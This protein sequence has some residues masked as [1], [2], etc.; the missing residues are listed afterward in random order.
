LQKIS[1]H[2]RMQTLVKSLIILLYIPARIQ[3]QDSEI[4]RLIAGELRMTFPSIYFKHNST[5]YAAMPY[6]ADSCFK[7]IALHYND[8][9]NSLVIWRDSTETEELTIKRIKKL[10]LMLGKYIRNGEIVIH[11][12]ENEQKISRRIINMTSDDAKISYLL[13]LNSVFDISKTR[14]PADKTPKGLDHILH[15]KIWCWKCWK[16]CFHIDKTSR[17]LRKMDRY[18]KKAK[19]TPK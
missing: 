4:D 5:D 17:A 7:H 10:K 1:G 18:M 9:M 14:F 6:T 8:D 12:M 19:K 16:S 13:S 3:G 15:P 2:K 11:P